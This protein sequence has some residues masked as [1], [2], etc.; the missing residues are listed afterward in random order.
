[1]MHTHDDMEEDLG[2]GLDAEVLVPLREIISK[3]FGVPLGRL[4][5]YTSLIS[6]GLD[7]IRSVGLS[8][9]LRQHG[10]SINAADIMGNPILRKLGV[11]CARSLGHSVE[12]EIDLGVLSLQKQCERIKTRLDPSTCKLSIDDKVEIFP[13]TAL[14]A[15][16]ISQVPVFFIC[17]YRLRHAHKTV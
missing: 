6:L 2:A 4:C 11:L 3:F 7:S 5:P 8:K 10:Y 13:T 9:I 16:M 12:T 15:G 17:F 1:M 14:Q